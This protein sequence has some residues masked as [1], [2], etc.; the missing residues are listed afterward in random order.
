MA[1]R[2]LSM[3]RPRVVM[4]MLPPHNTTATFLFLSSGREPV[5]MAPSPEAPAPSTTAFSVS[6]S[7]RGKE[8]CDGQK[9]SKKNHFL[10]TKTSNT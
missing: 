8:G 1:K 3:T 5:R 7:F 10:F 6:R 2:A 9:F 4:S